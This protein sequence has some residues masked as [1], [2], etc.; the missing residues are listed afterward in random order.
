MPLSNYT[1]A[2]ALKHRK[3]MENISQDSQIV[4]DYSLHW[5]AILLG[6]ASAGLLSI[7]SPQV[8]QSALGWNKCLPRSQTKGYPTSA[9][10]GL[11][12]S[13]LIWSVKNEIPNSS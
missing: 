6:T 2:Y 5:L 1:L 13:A 11:S 12:V 4:R 10:M 9:N 7:S 8:F 3:S